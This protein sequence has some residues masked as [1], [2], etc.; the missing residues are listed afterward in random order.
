MSRLAFSYRE[1]AERLGCSVS[2]VER[3]VKDGTLKAVRFGRLRRIP[4]DQVSAFLG[5][6]T[7][8]DHD[9]EAEAAARAMLKGGR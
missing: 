6:D 5:A 8:P 7:G 9:P 3:R 2:T 1:V 4:A